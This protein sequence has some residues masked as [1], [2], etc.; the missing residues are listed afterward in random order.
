MQR[1]ALIGELEK[2]EVFGLLVSNAGTEFCQKSVEKCKKLLEKHN[3]KY[4][5]FM[6]NNL[7]EVKLGN[8]P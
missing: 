7:N 1:L 4:Y 2:H 8:F 3:K 6:M 5:V